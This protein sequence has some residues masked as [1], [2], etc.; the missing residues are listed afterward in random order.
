MARYTEKKAIKYCDRVLRD[1]RAYGREQIYEG[2][3]DAEGRFYVLDGYRAYRLEELPVNLPE[4]WHVQYPKDVLPP[5]TV[6]VHNGV[7]KMFNIPDSMEWLIS[8]TETPDLEIVKLAKKNNGLYD[9]GFN[10]PCVNPS[11]VLDA[12]ELFP[13]GQWYTTIDQCI[14]SPIYVISEHGTAIILPVRTDKKYME[15]HG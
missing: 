2:F 3:C 13:D 8:E 7:F 4:T 11:Y 12:L 5:K 6:E 1:A 14:I 9:F 10:K 15:A